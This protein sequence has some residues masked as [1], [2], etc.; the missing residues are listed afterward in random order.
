[1][2]PYGVLHGGLVYALVDYAMGPRWSRAS[3]PASGALRW[4]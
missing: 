2:N 4:R 3:S 1:M